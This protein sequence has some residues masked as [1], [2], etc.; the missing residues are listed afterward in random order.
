MSLTGLLW[1]RDT[2]KDKDHK[3]P[4]SFL[5]ALPNFYVPLSRESCLGV[6]TSKEAPG[7][8]SFPLYSLD[9]IWKSF[10]QNIH[11]GGGCERDRLGLAYWKHIGQSLR[12]LIFP[13]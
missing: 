4:S 5:L 6:L 8:S 3:S 2:V 13:L 12:A 11:Y 9:V 7:F 1:V 10:I